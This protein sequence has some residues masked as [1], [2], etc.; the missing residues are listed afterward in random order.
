VGAENRG[1][2]EGGKKSQDF[3]LITF[4]IQVF[5]QLFFYPMIM[6]AFLEQNY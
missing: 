1:E 3:Q 2:R 6:E 4:W 5:S